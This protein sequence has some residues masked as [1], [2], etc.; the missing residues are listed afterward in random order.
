ML[1][2][3]IFSTQIAE[4]HLCHLKCITNIGI[5]IQQTL[6]SLAC[7]LAPR[8]RIPGVLTSVLGFLMVRSCRASLAAACACT[9][10]SSGDRLSGNGSKGV[11]LCRSDKAWQGGHQYKHQNTAPESITTLHALLQS[12]H[13]HTSTKHG[14]EGISTSI[15]TLHQKASQHCTHFYKAHTHTLLQS[16]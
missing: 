6:A 3:T 4:L 13:T 1:P 12:T 16:T 10:I 5:I 9:R 11:P 8:T 15:T 14:R 7:V 2:G